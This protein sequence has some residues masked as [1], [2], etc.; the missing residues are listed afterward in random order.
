M[1]Q[2]LVGIGQ[3]TANGKGKGLPAMVDRINAE[4]GLSFL[5]LRRSKPVAVLL[6]VEE[7]ERLRRASGDWEMFV[8][9]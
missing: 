2:E 9:R 3:A 6:S 7:Y 8:L 5:I 4:D 1:F